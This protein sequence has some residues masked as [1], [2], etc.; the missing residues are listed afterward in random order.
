MNGMILVE[1]IETATK[2]WA[3]QC[4]SEERDA[5]RIANRDRAL[6][7]KA[8]RPAVSVR[9]AVFAKMEEGVA[10]ASGGGRVIFPTRNLFYSVR[11]LIQD[12]TTEVLHWKYFEKL[13]ADWEAEYGEIPGR[14]CDPRGYFIE[15]HTGKIIPLGTREVESYT[16]PAHLYDKILYVEKKGFHEIFKVARTAELYDIGIACAEGYAT[17]AAKLLLSRAEK[18]F[19]MKLLCLDDADPFGYNIARR[20][21]QTR[22]NCEIE[23]AHMGLTIE[24][25]IDELG[26]EPEDFYRT[27]ALPE[28]LELTEREREFFEG[29]FDHVNNKG[30]KV[31]R[32]KRVELNSLAA[33]PDR[34]I[35]YVHRRLEELGCARKLIPPADVVRSRATACRDGELLAR[36]QAVV[37]EQLG[38]DAIANAL[39]DGLRDAV[40]VKDLRKFLRRWARE[41]K[42][43]GWAEVADRE[44]EARV[45]GLAEQLERAAN[46]KTG[47][48]RKALG[49]PTGP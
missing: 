15:P 18:Q 20:L 35:A 9:D 16:F 10:K 21:R 41:L 3:R 29:E 38:V 44:V 12:L 27:S 14:Y 17:N 2:K 4:R 43:E 7:A 37:H 8:E 39:A 42:P 13:V 26:L 5:N 40:P 19:R 47:A 46:V 31:Y 49:L 30:K 25:A 24:E 36:A 23:V 28:G 6:A 1:L 11:D 48:A 34:F 33:D 32:C 22:L 45:A